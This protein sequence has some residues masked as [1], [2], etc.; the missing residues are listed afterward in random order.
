M[1][2][3]V[4]ATVS[5]AAMSSGVHVSVQF[6]GFVFSRYAPGMELLD[7]I[8]DLFLVFL[9]KLHAVLHSGCTNL[10]S[11]Q[12]RGVTLSSIYYL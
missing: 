2:V 11:Q 6:R 9:R 10:Y 5:S 4:L 3:H 1:S 12:C 7:H 8:V